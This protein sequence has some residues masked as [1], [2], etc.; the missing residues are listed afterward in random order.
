[1]NSALAAEGCALLKTGI[2]P[3]PVQSG[4]TGL[5]MMMA[6]VPEVRFSFLF[7]DALFPQPL[8]RMQGLSRIISSAE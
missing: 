6:L 3:Q 4:R 1:M 5:E 7:D 8:T 2:F